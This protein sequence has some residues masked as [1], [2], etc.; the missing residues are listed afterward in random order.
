MSTSFISH[1]PSPSTHSRLHAATGDP[2]A[3]S[4]P[5]RCASPLLPMGQHRT[6][7]S[8]QTVD[9]DRL[10]QQLGKA[11]NR[12]S[13]QSIVNKNYAIPEDDDAEPPEGMRFNSHRTASSKPHRRTMMSRQK[14]YRIATTDPHQSS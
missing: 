10:S 7:S 8:L 11:T 12:Q 14:S 13:Q 5:S 3:E 6:P 2:P 1:S 9:P 4:Y